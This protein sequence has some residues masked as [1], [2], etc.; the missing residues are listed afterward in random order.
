MI[1]RRGAEDAEGRRD[2]KAKVEAPHTH[3]LSPVFSYPLRPSAP[4][5]PLR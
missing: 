3:A 2:I 5:A 4:S 1:Y